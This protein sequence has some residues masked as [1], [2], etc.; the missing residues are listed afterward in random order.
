MNDAKKSNHKTANVVSWMHT[1]IEVLWI[2][3]KEYTNL[4]FEWTYSIRL[5]VNW[6]N[7]KYWPGIFA[8]L[9]TQEPNWN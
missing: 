2:L 4:F 8:N 7:L 1:T 9:D 6:T 5:L 3:S